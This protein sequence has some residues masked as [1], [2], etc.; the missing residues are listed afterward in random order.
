[1][2]ELP[3]SRQATYR[4]VPLLIIILLSIVIYLSSLPNDFLHDDV[5]QIVKNPWI[6]DFGN[7]PDV[8]FSSVWSFLKEKVTSNYYRPMMH[9]IYMVDYKLFGFEPWGYHLTSM[10]INAANA[11]MVFF[12]TLFLLAGRAAGGGL[13]KGASGG[14]GSPL[15]LA[16]LSAA[17]L[18]TTHPV[19]TESVAWAASIPEL[20]FSLFYL[21]SFYC[22]IIYVSDGK[23]GP[24][25]YIVS[26]ISFFFSTLSKEPA[27]SLPLLML[28][29]DLFVRREPVRP[30]APLVKR[31]V[32]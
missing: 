2:N 10:I 27:L 29:Y 14:L 17:V 16:A 25:L 11:C 24:A 26:V 6:K 4:V 9:F 15:T 5:D 21:V 8:L 28:A 7:I 22:Y 3:S 31:Y 20:S 18:F 30:I 32:P 1:M 12:V 23:R 13:S 19:H